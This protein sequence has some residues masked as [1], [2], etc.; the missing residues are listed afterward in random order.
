MNGAHRRRHALF[1]SNP[2]VA[3]HLGDYVEEISVKCNYFS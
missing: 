3:M 2:K 1:D